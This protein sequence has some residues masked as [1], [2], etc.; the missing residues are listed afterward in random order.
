ML[1]KITGMHIWI[2]L[3]LEMEEYLFDS[4]LS[5]YTDQINEPGLIQ[6]EHTLLD[7]VSCPD[8]TQGVFYMI[9]LYTN[10]HLYIR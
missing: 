7:V 8:L 1:H 9:S 5:M 4:G 6:P 10:G 2:N 3:L